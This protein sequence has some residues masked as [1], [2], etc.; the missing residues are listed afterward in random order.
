M[1][2]KQNKNRFN[3]S[4]LENNGVWLYYDFLVSIFNCSAVKFLLD[5]EVSVDVE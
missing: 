5:V 2:S 3:E 1:E 4:N